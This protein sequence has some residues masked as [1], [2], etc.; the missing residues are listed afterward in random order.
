MNPFVEHLIYIRIPCKKAK[1]E[2]ERLPVIAE[3][4]IKKCSI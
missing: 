1:G 2:N 3:A 4:K